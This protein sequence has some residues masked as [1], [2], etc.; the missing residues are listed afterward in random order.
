VF[1]RLGPERTWEFDGPEGRATVDVNGSL[2]LDNE[3]AVRQAALAGL[4][5]ALL[6]TYI[7]G[8]DLQQNRLRALLPDHHPPQTA[9]YAT[10]LPNRYLAAKARVFVDYLVA[11]FGPSPGWDASRQSSST[12]Q[13]SA[14]V[15]D[16][17]GAS[18][19]AR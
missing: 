9:L 13:R 1:S 8:P 15:L 19:D 3:N 7:V 11:R 2:R 5:I 18:A 12:A 4:G 10:Y 16:A 6:P 17:R 14:V